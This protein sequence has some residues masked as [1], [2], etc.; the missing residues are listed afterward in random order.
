[1]NVK[2]VWTTPATESLARIRRALAP[3]ATLFLFYETPTPA[4]A[5][6][7]AARVTEALRANGFTEPELRSRSAT[8]IGLVSH[9][10]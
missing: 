6:Q 5:R 8:L 1:M 9:Q 3:D 2:L 4:R 7:A 10:A